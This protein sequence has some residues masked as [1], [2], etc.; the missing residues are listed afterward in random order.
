ME[1]DIVEDEENKFVFK[2][3]GSG[4]TFCN[5]LKDELTNDD[6]VDIATYTIKHPLVAEPKFFVETHDGSPRDA[7]SS[8]T[9][10]LQERN[11]DLTEQYGE[12]DI[13]A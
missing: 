13:K 12:L 4:H 1:I 6:D 9:E 2:L 10:R 11:E 5:A 3:V 8:A 7:L